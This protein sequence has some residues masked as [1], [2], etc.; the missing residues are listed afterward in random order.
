MQM[1]D[2]MKGQRDIVVATPGRLRDLVMSEPDILR[3]ISKTQTVSTLLYH[4]IL[5]LMF[6]ISSSST[7]PIPCSTWDSGTISMQSLNTFL[8]RPSDKHSSSPP[9]SLGQ[10]NKSLAARSTK[11]I[12]SLALWSRLPRCIPSH[13][14]RYPIRPRTVYSL[15]RPMWLSG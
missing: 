13:P 4:I 1:R 8:P 15:C 3:G 2:W 5:A 14:S 7:K 11:T 6:V 12:C 10:S 9:P